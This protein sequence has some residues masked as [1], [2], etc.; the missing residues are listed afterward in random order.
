MIKLIANWFINA[1]A[2]YIVSIILDG[3]YIKDFITALA[4][5]IIIGLVNALIKPILVIL[6]IPITLLSLGLFTFILNA[7]MLILASSITPGFEVR[8]FW[9][10]IVGSILLSIVSTVLHSLVR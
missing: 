8:G 3:I 6:T 1:L 7:L 2:L 9:T 4:A 10:A 5:V